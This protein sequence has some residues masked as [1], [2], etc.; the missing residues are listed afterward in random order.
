M[1]KKAT[2]IL[3]A[4]SIII[5]GFAIWGSI[6]SDVEIPNYQVISSEGQFEMREY[7]PTLVA[8][9]SVKGERREAIGDG[10]RLLADFIFGN[11]T[12]NAEIAMTAPVV[13]KEGEKIAM[14]APVT[15]QQ[16]GSNW[17]VQFIMPS[18]YSMETIPKPNNDKVNLK[19]VP[20]QKFLAIQFSGRTSES[21]VAEH[22]A[23]LEEY[24][25]QNDIKTIAAPVYA[26]YNPP[27]TL[28][29]LRRNEIL[30]QIPF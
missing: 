7:G 18:E 13:Q 5:S 19:E 25:K 24:I 3:V 14:T 4:I 20:A 21:N 10:F 29:F 26:F 11:N 23:K 30:V 27:W 1:K 28:P 22:M 6:I 9:V 8:E 12:G 15:Q 16:D 2:V 17:K